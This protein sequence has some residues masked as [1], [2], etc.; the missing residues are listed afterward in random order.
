MT[1]SHLTRRLCLTA[2]SLALL[3]GCADVGSGSTAKDEFPVVKSTDQDVVVCQ[4]I[5]TAIQRDKKAAADAQAAGRTAEAK[6]KENSVLAGV[7]G[8]KSVKGCDV[9]DLV[10][11]AASGVPSPG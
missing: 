1:V 9:T 2:A 3:S 4:S 10:P 11:A 8:A 7:E 5:R 6:S